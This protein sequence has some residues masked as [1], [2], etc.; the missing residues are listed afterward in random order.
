VT[1]TN[2]QLNDECGTWNVSRRIGCYHMHPQSLYIITQ[3]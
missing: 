2:T 3:H 1:T